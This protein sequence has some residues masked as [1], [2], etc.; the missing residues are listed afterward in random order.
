MSFTNLG[1]PTTFATEGDPIIPGSVGA[2]DPY[3]HTEK[4]RLDV[5][6]ERGTFSFE[7]MARFSELAIA[8]AIE[9]AGWDHEW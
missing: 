3:V 1:Y 9:Q 6:D 8:F 5:D 4:D 7:H 2:L